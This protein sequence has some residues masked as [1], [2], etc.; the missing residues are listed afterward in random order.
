MF[1]KEVPIIFN[2]FSHV[3]KERTK[4]LLYDKEQKKDAEPW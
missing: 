4:L 1:K 3:R 2:E